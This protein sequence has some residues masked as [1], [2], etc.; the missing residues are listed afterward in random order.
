M[1]RSLLLAGLLAALSAAHAGA[2]PDRQVLRYNVTH[3]V[4]G[5]IGSYSNIVERDGDMTTVLTQAHLKV[6][7]LGVV[8]HRQDAQREERWRGGRLMSFH[9]VTAT[10]GR[11]QVVNGEARGASFVITSPHGTITAPANV[12]PTNP[13][14]A[15]FLGSNTM[16]RV[17]NGAIEPV[18]VSGGGMTMLTLDGT[19]LPAR[20][21]NVEGR[22]RY[23]VWLS[24]PQQVPVKFTADD[25]SGTVTF[26]LTR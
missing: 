26:T 21:Y 1:R 16:M 9:G 5:D 20:E 2:A 24:E 11:V 17:D 12:R 10:G 18:R 3:S 13:W 15:N 14:S 25:D 4:Y 7:V 22:T 8:L 6:S 23:A 19:R